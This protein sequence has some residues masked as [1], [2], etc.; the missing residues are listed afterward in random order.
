MDSKA[1]RVR[2]LQQKYEVNYRMP[3]KFYKRWEE[4]RD[5]G[6]ELSLSKQ[7]MKEVWSIL[8]SVENLKGLHRKASLSQLVLIVCVIIKKRYNRRYTG[9][10]VLKK[11]GVSDDMFHL[12]CLRLL[13]IYISKGT[14]AYFDPFTKFS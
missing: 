13:Y 5:F 7:E 9:V 11:Y 14:N 6:I 12:V 8:Y 1:R 4:L 3:K 10:R 2:Y